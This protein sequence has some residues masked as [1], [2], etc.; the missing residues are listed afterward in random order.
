MKPRERNILLALSIIL[1]TIVGGIFAWNIK[2]KTATLEASAVQVSD[3]WIRAMQRGDTRM[4]QELSCNRSNG[5]LSVIKERLPMVSDI[6]SATQEARLSSVNRQKDEVVSVD[7]TLTLS[8]EVRG[9]SRYNA[10]LSLDASKGYCISAFALD[11]AAWF[12]FEE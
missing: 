4:L 12:H 6:L 10:A 5:H 2:F 1:L 11:K 7:I 3:A 8:Y 9:T